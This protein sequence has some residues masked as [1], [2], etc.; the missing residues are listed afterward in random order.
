MVSLR[1]FERH[2]DNADSAVLAGARRLREPD[3]G[4]GIGI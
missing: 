1:Y 3:R 4:H 2:D